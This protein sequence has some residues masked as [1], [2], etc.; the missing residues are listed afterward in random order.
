MIFYGELLKT[1]AFQGT[2]LLFWS[3]LSQYKSNSNFFSIL[4]GLASHPAII[5]TVYIENK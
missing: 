2:C 1:P 4:D 5:R 3:N